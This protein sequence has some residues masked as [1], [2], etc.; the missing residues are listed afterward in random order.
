MDKKLELLESLKAKKKYRGLDDLLFF[1]KY[2]LEGD[3]ERRKL[4]VEH[5]HGEWSEWYKNSKARIKVVLVPRACFKST[6]FT[7]GKALQDVAANRDSR[8]LVAN[9]TL[10]N[11]QKFLGDIKNHLRKN[12]ELISLYGSFYDKE[13]KWNENE[14][15]VSGRSLGAREPTITAAGV[16][17]NL[18]SQHYSKII[19]D[20]LMN[21]ENSSTRY[22]VDKVVDWWKRSF[23]L[24]D[25]DGEMIVIGTRWSYYDLYAYI[26]DKFGEQTDFY[27]RGAYNED[28][29]L[30]FP[31]LLDEEKLE[32]LKALQGSYVFSS[33][34][35]N[36]PVDE[37]SALVKKSQIKYWGPGEENQLPKNL[38]VFAM[39]DPAFSQR[40]G[41]DESSIT[42]AGVDWDNN[43]WVLETRHGIWTV[44]Q[45]IEEL[46]A[47]NSQWKP[48][49]I[50]IETI[51][52]GQSITTPIY[53]EENRRGKYLNLYEITVRDRTTKEM[54]VRAVLQPR[55]ERGKI[56]IRRDMFDLEEQLLRFPRGKRDDMVDSLTDLEEIA[57]PADPE[58]KAHEVSAEY[59]E[60]LLKRQTQGIK[61]FD[62]YMGEDF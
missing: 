30:Y 37:E 34:Y 62:S 26:M 10:G 24:L 42:V 2:I 5:V 27:V 49:Q 16:G 57:F 15:E 19:A 55:F 38:A 33:F 7:V 36:D 9:A 61:T 11:S 13:L 3:P 18:V 14:I 21:L 25:Y 1:N 53:D 29:S 17:G 8:I 59:F 28:G 50:S 51:G 39:C 22:Q 58:S 41:A 43:W 31:E 32:E 12:N 46:F 6:F 54:R 47:V 56:Y 44:T 20:D 4:F 23:S 35:L 45:L 48:Q 40:E 60:E 52:Q